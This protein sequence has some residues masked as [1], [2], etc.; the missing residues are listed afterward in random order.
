MARINGLLLFVCLSHVASVFGDSYATT[1]AAP[2]YTT[3]T[4][5]TTTTKPPSTSSCDQVGHTCTNF[6]VNCQK[7]CSLGCDVAI[8]K[9]A[10]FAANGFAYP[11]CPTNVTNN[12]V[13]G[14][15]L[16]DYYNSQCGLGIINNCDLAVQLGCPAGATSTDSVANYAA[17]IKALCEVWNAVCPTKGLGCKEICTVCPKNAIASPDP[18]VVASTKASQDYSAYVCGLYQGACNANAIAC[19]DYNKL[20]VTPTYPPTTTYK[21]AY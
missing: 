20:C 4:T 14:Q 12:A 10:S 16:C 8:A 5:T 1:T 19:A 7:F 3:T 6:G 18:C 15:S 9:N 11:T 21:S 13:L 2:V 17:T